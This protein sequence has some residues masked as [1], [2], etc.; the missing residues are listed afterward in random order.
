MALSER[1]APGGAGSGYWTI[2]PTTTPARSPVPEVFVIVVLLMWNVAANVAVPQGWEIPAA[3]VGLTVLLAIAR[4]AGLTWQALG[5]GRQAFSFGARLGLVLAALI[6]LAVVIL[7]L[8]P[9]T[10]EWLADDR[11]VNVPGAEV[12]YDLLLR[13]PLA[14][15]LAEEI[16][17]RGVLLGMLLLWMAPLRA[18]LLSSALFGLW[19][20]LPGIAALDT[21]AVD[22]DGEIAS[23][24]A[25]AAQVVV[26]GVAGV[27]FCW[28]RIRS[29]HLAAPVL[30]HWALNGSAYLAG[31]LVVSAE[32][33]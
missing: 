28:L 20:V 19:H 15:A 30:A 26:T 17:F 13:I 29:R 14:T 21:A 9:P 12:T 23:A 1:H 33:S 16:A 25:V 22:V 10:R 31:W 8:V 32:W 6:G 7:T 24:G 2:A 11:F 3:L 4:S 5:L 18:V 27:A